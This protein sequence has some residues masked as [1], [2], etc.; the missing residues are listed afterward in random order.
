MGEL[1]GPGLIICDSACGHPKT[2]AQIAR[3]GLDFI[4]PLRAST[5]FR[6]RFLTDVGHGA[7]RKLDY[8]SERERKLPAPRRTRYRGALTDWEITDRIYALTSIVGIALLIF[9]LIET[10]L[11]K[12]LDA[13]GKEEQL[14]G[15]LPEVGTSRVR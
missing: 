13:Q 7:L 3:S 6:E 8:V 5:G 1:A 2:L 14:P 10:E 11:R 9:G 4:V 15:L 12:T